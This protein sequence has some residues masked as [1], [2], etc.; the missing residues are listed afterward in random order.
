MRR[1]EIWWA[2]MGEYRGHEQGGYRPVLILQND[3]G[4]RESPTTLV[5]MLTGAQKHELPT[6]I[7]VTTHECNLRRDSIIMAEQIRVVDKSFLR[8]FVGTLSQKKMQEVDN[9]VALSLSLGKV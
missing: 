7:K 6:H 8:V 1:G 4:N 9:A 3:V 5:A 2:D